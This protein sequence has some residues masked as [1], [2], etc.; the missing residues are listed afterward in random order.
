MNKIINSLILGSLV[1]TFF[2]SPVNA[3]DTK[4]NLEIARAIT[5]RVEGATQ[6]SG[7]ITSKTD[8]TYSVLTAWHVLKPNRE[9]EEITLITSDGSK[10]T[11]SRSDSNRIGDYDLGIIKFNSSKTHRIAKISDQERTKFGEEIIV[12]GFPIQNTLKLETSIGKSRGQLSDKNNQGYSLYY[13]A[14]TGPGMSGG[15][16]LNKEGELVAIHGRGVR[17][18]SKNSRDG[19]YFKTSIN[20]GIPIRLAKGDQRDK[21]MIE[22]TEKHPFEYIITAINILSDANSK[23]E[24][25][26]Q[27][28]IDFL[29]KGLRLSGRENNPKARAT[30]QYLGNHYK[31]IAYGGLEISIEAVKYFEKSIALHNSYLSKGELNYPLDETYSGLGLAYKRL[32]KYAQAEAAYSRALNVNKGN[33]TATINMANLLILLGRRDDAFKMYYKALNSDNIKS[34]QIKKS[35][36]LTNIGLLYEKGRQHDKSIDMYNKAIKEYKL[37]EA[38]ASRG[39]AYSRRGSKQQA[40]SDLKVATQM[41]PTF[42]KSWQ[43]L[44]IIY[45][46]MKKYPMAI[47][48]IDRVINSH[49]SSSDKARAYSIKANIFALKNDFKSAIKLRELA[50]SLNPAM[51]YELK[52]LEQNKGSLILSRLCKI[53]SL[54]SKKNLSRYQKLQ[55]DLNV[56][57]DTNDYDK[58][59]RITSEMLELCP[60]MRA[61]IQ[62]KHYRGRS[63]FRQAVQSGSPA[64]HR[65]A[66]KDFEFVKNNSKDETL[67]NAADYFLSTPYLMRK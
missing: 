64:L 4:N 41:E 23:V 8:G 65:Q 39:V 37:A 35:L 34:S 54:Q 21:D 1:S 9:G 13:F 15:P 25:P 22:S 24:V 36:L 31:G 12:S 17:N 27:A 47:N 63:Y 14:K 6:G 5:V 46:H 19:Q 51:P 52:L 48:A 45:E 11:V 32:L 28:A 42:W 61:Y 50:L 57:K 55:I 18:I 26:Y 3:K 40:L 58:T 62:L 44:A 60:V 59:I 49:A 30:I 56:S 20:K 38:F 2:T 7:V 29:D 43:D 33:I 16:I 66:T 53:S 67:L 10:Y